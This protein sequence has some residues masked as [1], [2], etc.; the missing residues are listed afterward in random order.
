M[1]IFDDIHWSAEM[2]QAWA[3]IKADQRVMMTIDLFFFGLVVLRDDFKV[4]QDF[5]IRF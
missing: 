5:T 3:Q 2:E 1:L 4:K